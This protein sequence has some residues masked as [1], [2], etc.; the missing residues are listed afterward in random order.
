MPESFFILSK[1][2]LDLAIDEIISIARSY[3]RFTKIQVI[4]NL[5]LMQTKTSWKII[6]KRA[7]FVKIAGLAMRKMSNLFLDDGSKIQKSSSFACRVLNLS[8]NKIDTEELERSMGNMISKFSNASVDLDNPELVIYLIFAKDINFFGLSDERLQHI[9]PRKPAKFNHELDWKL[10]RAM[11]NLTGLKEGDSICDPFCGTGTSLIEAKSLGLNV[12]G[13]DID[14]KMIQMCESNLKNNDFDYKLIN[15][16]YSEL[17]KIRDEF[18]GI[19]TDIPYGK[20]SKTTENPELMLRNLM[21]IIPSGKKF[22]IMCKK[23]HEV[24]LNAKIAK[25]YDIY[26][27]KSLTRTILVK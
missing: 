9:R 26:R 16:D 20:S 22:A 21:K 6:A 2:Y 8:T 25:K 1:E 17:I 5:V 7:T 12:I 4:S 24:G 14:P 10:S 13:I 23:G 11:I 19:V 18:D 3:D 15:G 27:H